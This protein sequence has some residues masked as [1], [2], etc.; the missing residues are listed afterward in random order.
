MAA[1]VDTAVGDGVDVP[2]PGEFYHGPL[3][4]YH[5]QRTANCYGRAGNLSLAPW[6]L[7]LYSLHP[8]Q[9]SSSSRN[10]TF[11]K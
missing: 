4:E 10:Q 1:V 9:L 3:E 11:N 8:Y 2:G 6:L 7:D 5:E